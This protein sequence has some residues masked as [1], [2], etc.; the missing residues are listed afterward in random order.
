MKGSNVGPRPEPD[1][2][3]GP[4]RYV[5]GAALLVP[6]AIVVIGLAQLPGMSV[7]APTRALL[8]DNGV[9]IVSRRPA[10][11]QSGPPPTLMAPTATPRPTATPV[12]PTPSPQPTA[13]PETGRTYQVR[14]GDQLKN[15]AAQYHVSIWKIIA[16][17]DIPNPDSLRVGQVLRIPDE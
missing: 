5:L 11:S 14:R 6:L 16:N 7:A 2:G 17:N 1:S 4:E 13:T 10:S 15:I 9:S 12:P 8:G 3:P